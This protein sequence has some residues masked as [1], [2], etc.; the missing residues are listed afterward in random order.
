MRTYIPEQIITLSFTL[1]AG[2]LSGSLYDILRVIRRKLCD[3]K[4]VTL[5]TD[6]L[7]GVSFAAQLFLLAYTNG[8]GVFRLYMPFAALLGMTIYFMLF[9]KAFTALMLLFADFLEKIISILFYPL[10]FVIKIAKKSAKLIKKIFYYRKK[11]YTIK[12]DRNVC[13]GDGGKSFAKTEGHTNETEKGKYY[14]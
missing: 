10:I 14:Y 5:L 8:E 4:I 1:A 3:G 2:V 11:W 9:S 7:F 6:V 13:Q 12:L